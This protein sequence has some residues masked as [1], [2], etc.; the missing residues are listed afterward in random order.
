MGRV[1]RLELDWRM[2]GYYGG[3][4]DNDDDDD[5]DRLVTN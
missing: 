4:D 2:Y 5:V 3:G 1:A